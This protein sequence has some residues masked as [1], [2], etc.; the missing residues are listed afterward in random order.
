MSYGY[1]EWKSIFFLKR[2]VCNIVSLMWPISDFLGGGIL[3]LANACPTCNFD[4]FPCP[5]RH[6]KNGVSW[7][8][9]IFREKQ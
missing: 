3:K 9:A 6:D 7:V 4:V 5:L 1:K 8:V 2:S